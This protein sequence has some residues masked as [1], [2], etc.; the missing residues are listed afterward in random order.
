MA[1]KAKKNQQTLHYTRSSCLLLTIGEQ[2]IRVGIVE[3]LRSRQSSRRRV[4]IAKVIS[5]RNLAQVGSLVQDRGRLVLGMASAR[6]GGQ[7][8]EENGAVSHDRVTWVC[9]GENIALTSAEDISA[10]CFAHPRGGGTALGC[11]L[12][13]DRGD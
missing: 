4:S 1:D 3:G 10:V 8:R 13:E 6:D 5:A 12:G 11:N 7:C 9:V 2:S